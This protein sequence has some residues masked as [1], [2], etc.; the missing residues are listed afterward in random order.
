MSMA[1]DR[2]GVGLASWRVISSAEEPVSRRLRHRLPWLAMGLAGAMLSAWI[3]GFAEDEI[4]RNVALAFFMPAIVYMADAVGTQTEVLVVRSLSAGVPLRD[5]FFKEAAAG[6]LI[7]ALIAV[8]FFPFCLVFYD[9]ANLA[10]TVSLAL[11]VS[12]SAAGIIA[13]VL[14]WLLSRNGADPAFGSGPLATVIQDLLSIVI[15]LAL[16]TVIM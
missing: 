2:E 15:Y 11:F 13:L 8:A 4:S 5:F 6:I 10:L 3:V 14:P 7:G 16:A 9:Q 1:F 12:A